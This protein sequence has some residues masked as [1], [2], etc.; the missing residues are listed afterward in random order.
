VHLQEPFYE[1]RKALITGSA[2]PTTDEIIEGERILKEEMDFSPPPRDSAL[3]S[4]NGIPN[5]WLT[6]LQHSDDI[7]LMIAERDIEVLKHLVDIQC[8]YHTSA[9]NSNPGFTLKFYFEQNS[10]FSNAVLEKAYHY[11]LE[12][13]EKQLQGEDY[14]LERATGTVIRQER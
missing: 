13:E 12:D 9:T 7:A 10:F 8:V 3:Y 11:K 14:V 1:R 4:G 5:F 2:K 6:A